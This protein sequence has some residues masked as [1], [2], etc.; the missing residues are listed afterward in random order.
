M[1]IDG[2]E[3]AGGDHYYGIKVSRKFL[4]AQPEQVQRN[5]ALDSIGSIVN[6]RVHAGNPIILEDAS[7]ALTGHIDLISKYYGYTAAIRDFNAVMNYTFHE[8]AEHGGT[9]NAFAGSV[10]ETLGA[11]WGAGAGKYLDNLLADL[12]QK[13]SINETAAQIMAKLR[14]NLAAASLTLN[15]AVAL[16]Q[17]ASLPGAAQVLGVDGV[18]AGLKP[19]K[20]DMVLIEKY[21]PILWY[22]NQGNS[23]QELGDYMATKGMSDK[24]PWWANWIQKMDAWTIRR[25]WAGAEYRVSKDTDLSPG[26]KE[27]I[28]AGEDAYYQEV[29]RVFQRAV[30]D[31]QPNYSEM[32]RPAILRSKSDLTKALTM[33]K[34]VPIQYYN[35]M[36]EAVGRLKADAA[37]AKADPGNKHYQA[38]LSKSK[39][40]AVKTFTG[41][42]GA[43]VTYVVMKALVKGLLGGKKD[44]FLDEEG[45]LDG[46]RIFGN[47]GKDLIDTYAGSVIFGSDLLS[48]GEKFVDAITTGKFSRYGGMEIS[49]LSAI[50]D[51]MGGI[52]NLATELHDQDYRGG[53]GATKDLAKQLAMVCGIP[54][55]NAETYLLGITK[56]ISP[57]W[58]A[59]YENLFDEIERGDLK[60]QTGRDLRAAF[61][62]LMDN[63]TDGLKDE[64][65]EELVRLWGNGQ[66][67][68]VPSA[69][70]TKV[71]IEGEDHTLTAGERAAFRESWGKIV[72]DNLEQLIGSEGYEQADDAGKA[73]LIKKLYDYAR[74]QAVEAAVGQSPDA[75]VQFGKACVDAGINLEDYLNVAA[76]GKD[77]LKDMDGTELD[78]AIADRMRFRIGELDG[79]SL[80]ELGRLWA[81]GATD[82]I[83]SDVPTSI[84]VGG[85]EIKFSPEERVAWMQDWQRTAG[86]SLTTVMGSKAYKAADDAGKE[87]LISAVY[88]YARAAASSGVTDNYTPD[89]WILIGREAE[90]RG[91]DADEYIL[92]H[93]QCKELKSVEKLDL[94]KKQGW[95]ESQKEYIWMASMATEAQLTKYKPLKN[96][97]VKWAAA[98]DLMG[99][100]EASTT[101]MTQEETERFQAAWDRISGPATKKLMANAAYKN[102]DKPTQS[103][104]IDKLNAYVTQT[105]KAETLKGYTIDKWVECGQKLSKAGVA[106]DE[107]IVFTATTSDASNR[108]KYAALNKTGWTESQKLQTM[109]YISDSTHRVATVGKAYQVR[110]N[111]YLDA[112]ANA[113]ADQ[114]GNINQEEA[115]AYIDRLNLGWE[116]KAYLWQMV[117]ATSRWK[118]NPYSAGFGKEIW[119]DLHPNG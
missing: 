68:Q 88:D 33:Y 86:E 116:D 63:R 8:G 91:I 112:L 85:T 118:N 32:Q 3:R 84:T 80:D 1:Q 111:Y 107:Y 94:L 109:A 67:V 73:K 70:Q 110:L 61:R 14:G 87:K 97:G 53:V 27:Q 10:K 35:M 41:I 115:E 108:D 15:P 96:S 101:G 17:T 23:T 26:S 72:S 64:T 43:N 74:Q 45:K 102:A 22:R 60:G 13:S 59:R 79:D 58:A 55:N 103:A 48:F 92:F 66:T 25:L 83:P 37:R 78:A 76:V 16:S 77:K 46:G 49:F 2:F 12:Q 21:T 71:S 50:E 36:Y 82:V 42:L 5:L 24:L 69:V 47:L 81:A 100:G 95:T 30:Y 31:T 29:A 40:F 89:K 65:V 4:A 34:T 105:A 119:Y 99:V 117:C 9:A 28:D 52:Y 6:E 98:L 113:D 20:V 44:R 114:S 51:V 93:Q 106:L 19:E 38:E 104:Y 75:W 90:A 39:S 56:L 57:E 18:I 11:K 54:A 62:V 7:A